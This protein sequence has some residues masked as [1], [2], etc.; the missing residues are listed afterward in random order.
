MTQAEAAH[1]HSE[2]I[3]I[4]DMCD[5]FGPIVKSY[6]RSGTRKPC[7]V[8]FRLNIEGYTTAA[9]AQWTPR[10]SH[11][12][13]GL[14]FAEPSPRNATKDLP[15]AAVPN[16]R[17]GAEQRRRETPTLT[18][19]ELVNRLSSLGRVILKGS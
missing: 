1:F 18:Q 10:L 7:D 5:N 15:S 17:P 14:I 6:A 9:G 19:A 11:F 13:L 4:K 2:K 12:L 8:A 16:P 3:S